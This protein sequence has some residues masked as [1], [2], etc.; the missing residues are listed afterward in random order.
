MQEL[1]RENKVKLP[2]DDR[3]KIGS[4][5]TAYRQGYHVVTDIELRGD[6]QNPLIH[7][8]VLLTSKGTPSKRIIDVC[9]ASFCVLASEEIPKHIQQLEEHIAALKA[10]QAKY[11]L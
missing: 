7:Y 2:W 11:E 1:I 3:I 5:I 9:D 8:Q 4:I 10:L 6:K